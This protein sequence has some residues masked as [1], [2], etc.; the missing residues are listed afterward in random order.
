M[1]IV[2]VR[3]LL[4]VLLVS[5]G[6]AFSLKS[7]LGFTETFILVTILQFFIA[8]F[9]KNFTIKK[10]IQAVKEITEDYTEVL[11]K[12]VV[13]VACPCGKEINDIIVFAAEEAIVKCNKCDN[14]FKV[15]CDVRTQLVTEPLNLEVVYDQLKEK[16][17]Q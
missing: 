8:F 16:K 10:E 2:I 13:S 11:E 7:F 15:I 6:I 5:L 3:S 17:E 12:C 14:D 4:I 9:W 1:I